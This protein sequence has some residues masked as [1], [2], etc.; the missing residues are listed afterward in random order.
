MRILMVPNG[1]SEVSRRVR[2]AF[3]FSSSRLCTASSTSSCSQRGMRRC[4][5]GVQ[6]LLSEQLLLG[7]FQSLSVARCEKVQILQRIAFGIYRPLRSRMCE[8]TCP[9]TGSTM[10]LALA[11]RV[12]IGDR[13]PSK[14][15][16]A[17]PNLE[18][19]IEGD[20]DIEWATGV[21]RRR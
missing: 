8:L 11:I 9:A 21:S 20:F 4:G 5:P 7:I 6:R 15:T 10:E 1:C 18:R 16:T 14:K 13:P 19:P 2:I 17:V 12:G 3:G